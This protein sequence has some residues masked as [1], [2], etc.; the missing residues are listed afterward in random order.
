MRS[1]IALGLLLS[2]CNN[3]VAVDD[4]DG[5]QG[6]IDAGEFLID[7]PAEETITI[8]FTTEPGGIDLTYAPTNIVAT[9]IEGKDGVFVQTIDRQSSIRTNSLVAWGV[10]AGPSDTDAVTGATRLNHATPVSATWTIPSNQ[11]DGMYSIRIE[12]CDANVVTAAD[13]AQG[14]FSF[15]KDGVAFNLRDLQLPGYTE[16]SIEYSGR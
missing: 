15:E 8:T 2:A 1:L 16:V 9:W 11:P 7:A 5:S 10:R 4:P 6:F 13:N 3:F 14:V 12:T